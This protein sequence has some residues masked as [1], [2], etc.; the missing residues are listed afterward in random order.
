MSA[1]VVAGDTSGSVTLSAPAV[2]GTATITL[3]TQNG[4]I[5]MAEN[6]HMTKSEIILAQAEYDVNIIKAKRASE[7]PPIT[8]YIDG[9]VKG[10]LM[11]QQTY[12]DACRAIK[13]KYPK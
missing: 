11:Q 2:A 7:Y 4:T 8:D 13:A 10:D 1:L 6:L 9:I 5:T 3:P 12:I